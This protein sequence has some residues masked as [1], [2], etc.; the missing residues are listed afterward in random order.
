[1]AQMGYHNRAAFL[2]FVKRE[3]V[4]FYRLGARKIMFD[5]SEVEAWLNRHKVG[6]AA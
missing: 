6:G 3:G 2:E 4:P 1:M 5:P